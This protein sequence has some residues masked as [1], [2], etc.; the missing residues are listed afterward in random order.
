[1]FVIVHIL[2]PPAS[3]TAFWTELRRIRLP[4]MTRFHLD[5]GSDSFPETPPSDSKETCFDR[6]VELSIERSLPFW[7]SNA[8]RLLPATPNRYNHIRQLSLSGLS[9]EFAIQWTTFN[10]IIQSVPSLI[11][12]SMMRVEFCGP[13]PSGYQLHLPS[14]IKLKLALSFRSGDDFVESL[15]A[16]NLAI[17]SISADASIDDLDFFCWREEPLLSRIGTV[18]LSLRFTPK[19]T[20]FVLSLRR[21][22]GMMSAVSCLDLRPSTQFSPITATIA[23]LL[24]YP[25]TEGDSTHSLCPKLNCVVIDGEVTPEMLAD[26]LVKSHIA[27]DV[28]VAQID[29]SSRVAREFFGHK[30]FIFSRC[31]DI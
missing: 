16:P 17:L 12:L 22:L 3:S 1:M 31:V 28:V 30:G 20:H 24:L 23:E 5:L 2:Q 29:E 25:G 6:V 18:E 10:T 21:L 19:D 14:L 7:D 15:D 13:M 4:L 9:G 26:I 27:K 8:A 11:F